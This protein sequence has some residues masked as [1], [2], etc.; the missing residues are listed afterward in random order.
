MAITLLDVPVDHPSLKSIGFRETLGMGDSPFGD[1]YISF[2][3]K[4]LMEQESEAIWGKI[5]GFGGLCTQCFWDNDFHLRITFF[6]Q[7]RKESPPVCLK[8]AIEVA[9]KHFQIS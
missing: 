4:E 2:K 8:A 3:T 1:L 7:K 5:A 9:A 6:D